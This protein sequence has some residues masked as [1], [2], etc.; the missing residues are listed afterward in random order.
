VQNEGTTPLQVWASA[1][2]KQLG[3]EKWRPQGAEDANV[4][5]IP[6]KSD[7]NRTDNSKI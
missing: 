5:G 3:R 2:R 7:K 4:R 6:F 1:K